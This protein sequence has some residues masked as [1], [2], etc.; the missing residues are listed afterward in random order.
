VH[1]GGP[2]ERERTSDN[3]SFHG[4]LY[5]S[6]DDKVCKHV[7]GEYNVGYGSDSPPRYRFKDKG[8][9]RGAGKT[10][11]EYIDP[12]G[13]LDSNKG[14]WRP[15]VILGFD[16]AHLLTGLPQRLPSKHLEWTLFSELRR[17]LRELVDMPM[18]SLFLS[19]AGSANIFSPPIQS[20]PSSLVTNLQELTLH[21][22]QFRR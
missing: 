10:L 13:L 5:F 2:R 12:Q 8:G 7:K 14:P 1:G 17:V 4:P 22:T 9:V 21:Y 18:L 16:E 3:V 15:L 19:T 6:E 11:C 20:N